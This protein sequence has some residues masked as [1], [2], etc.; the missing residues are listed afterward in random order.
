[1]CHLQTNTSNSV[2]FTQHKHHTFNC[3]VFDKLRCHQ[4]HRIT[5]IESE[6]IEI[7]HP[8]DWKFSNQHRKQIE[9]HLRD[10]ES[11]HC[12]RTE[13]II[14]VPIGAV[15]PHMTC[16]CGRCSATFVL[17]AIR[18]HACNGIMTAFIGGNHRLAGAVV[19]YQLTHCWNHANMPPKN[20]IVAMRTMSQMSYSRM[21]T[22]RSY[23]YRNL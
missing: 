4:M 17:N 21:V 7:S 22:K 18:W 15:T 12:K 9:F 13:T 23:C 16:R 1:M 3:F 8:A 20:V 2:I 11:K 10:N 5:T 19:D 14:F 6:I